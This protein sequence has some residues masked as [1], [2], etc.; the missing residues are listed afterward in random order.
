MSETKQTSETKTEATGVV[1]KYIGGGDNFVGIPARD[2]TKD[3][4][5]ALSDEQ[6]K[7]VTKS[8]VYK[9]GGK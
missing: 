5:D 3:D 8:G 2:L 9:K 6:Q 7:I 4:F 1:F